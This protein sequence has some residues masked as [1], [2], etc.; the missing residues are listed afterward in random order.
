MSFLFTNSSMP[1]GPSSPRGRRRRPS[2]LDVL[3]PADVADRVDYGGERVRGAG[4]APGHG[5][6][7]TCRQS[8]LTATPGLPG[9]PVIAP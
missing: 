8:R 9:R 4:V 2:Q 1:S 5:E 6:P 3:M 7:E